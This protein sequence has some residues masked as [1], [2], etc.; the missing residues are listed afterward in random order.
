MRSKQAGISLIETLLVAGITLL[1]LLGAT[2]TYV[3]ANNFQSK[4]GP[5]EERLATAR[6]FEDRITRLLENA[7]LSAAADDVETFFVASTAGGQ[8]ITPSVSESATL[9]DSLCFTSIGQQV[10]GAYINSTDTFENL[11]TQYGPQGGIGEYGISMTAVGDAGSRQGL[12]I[13]EQ[14]PS[15][16][17]AFQ[18]G[19]ESV[20]SENV[21]SIGFEFYDGTQWVTEWDTTTS[22][23]KRLPAAVRITYTLDNDEGNSHT[24]V[25]R[26]NYSDVT[27]ENPAASGG[28]ST[29]TTGGTQ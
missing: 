29:G 16:G 4:V 15:D 1:M 12:F 11:N 7:Y 28:V 17:D 23:E 3:A 14:R 25:V 20:M 9:P 24:V 13:R 21:T 8:E 6:A 2:S 10:S 22:G 5:R 26:L 19:Y 18:G 27:P